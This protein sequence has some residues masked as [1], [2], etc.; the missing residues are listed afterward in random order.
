MVT[1]TSTTGAKKGPAQLPLRRAMH[2]FLVLP[3]HLLSGGVA[4]ASL[5][6]ITYSEI[7]DIFGVLYGCN[8]GRP[9]IY[10]TNGKL[11]NKRRLD[12]AKYWDKTIDMGECSA[13]VLKQD[14]E[15]EIGGMGRKRSKQALKMGFMTLYESEIKPISIGDCDPWSDEYLGIYKVHKLIEC[16]ES[17]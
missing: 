8:D 17:R 1:Q 7:E 13:V 4:Q 10:A 9:Y 11:W 16:W 2:R 5:V 15:D 12:I 6:I 3:L 14:W